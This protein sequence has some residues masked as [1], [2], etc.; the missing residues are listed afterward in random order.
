MLIEAVKRANSF[1]PMKVAETFR[2]IQWDS[3]FGPMTIGMESLYGIKSSACRPVP[4]GIIKQGK[5]THLATVPWPS[6][7]M[8]KKLSA[9]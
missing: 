5:P 6:D 4:M 3:I 8:I 1:D 7:E 9:N 2:F